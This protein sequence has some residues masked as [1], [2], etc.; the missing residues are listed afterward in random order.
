MKSR[1]DVTICCR[2]D[3]S[4][5][6]MERRMRSMSPTILWCGNFGLVHYKWHL[7]YLCQ[8]AFSDDFRQENTTSNTCVW[9]KKVMLQKR[10]RGGWEYLVIYLIVKFSS[11]VRRTRNQFWIFQQNKYLIY[12][13]LKNLSVQRGFKNN[14]DPV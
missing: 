5:R 10:R 1:G 12:I 9:G 14:V 13:A 3:C 7:K 2:L 11:W 4:R 6:E 8:V